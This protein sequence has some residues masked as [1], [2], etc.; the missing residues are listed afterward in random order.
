MSDQVESKAC[1]LC[2]GTPSI[3]PFS[4]AVPYEPSTYYAGERLSCKCGLTLKEHRTDDNE[5]ILWDEHDKGKVKEAHERLIKR[6]NTRPAF[7]ALA[8]ERDALLARIP[9]CPPC[10][11]GE[12][13]ECVCDAELV[14]KPWMDEVI[15]ERDKARAALKAMTDKGEG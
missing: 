12:N 8:K 2:K 1:P 7:D 5:K 11:M 14:P 10:D 13:T 6:W 4:E 3:G 15:K 9:D